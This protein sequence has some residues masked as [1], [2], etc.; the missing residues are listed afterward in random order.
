TGEVFED[1]NSLLSFPIGAYHYVFLANN[2]SLTDTI[3]L[4]QFLLT[5]HTGFLSSSHYKTKCM[6]N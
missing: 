2:P 4:T 6:E 5:T 1:L 3:M